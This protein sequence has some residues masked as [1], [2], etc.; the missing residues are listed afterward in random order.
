MKHL[1][2]L[3]FLYLILFLTFQYAALAQIGIGT[4]SPDASAALDITSTD[5]GLLIPRMTAY[6]SAPVTG[7]TVYRT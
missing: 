6:P 4:T 7:L 1:S 2:F 3:R 5:K